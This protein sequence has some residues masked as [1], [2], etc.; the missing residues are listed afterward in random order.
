MRVVARGRRALA[1]HA[2]RSFR[3]VLR[4]GQVREQ[5]EALE[6][7]ADAGALARDGAV[8]QFVQLVPD[9]AEADELAGDEDGAAVDA[10]E[11]VDAAQEGALARARRPDDADDL[12]RRHPERDALQ[13]LKRAEA[14][15]DL[16][17]DDERLAAAGRD[18]RDLAGLAHR[19]RP[20]WP[21][22]RA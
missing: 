4:D 12:A 6:H 20:A 18:V 9:A 14:L 15:D 8:V 3:D 10:L 1:V 17:R 16:D 22:P 19:A 11:L 7:H 2:D 13:H 5:V 21:V